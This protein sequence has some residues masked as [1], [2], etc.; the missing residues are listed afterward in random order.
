MSKVYLLG[1]N[2][3]YDRNIPTVKINQIIILEGYGGARY[4]VYDITQ[5]EYG[6][7]YH[8]IN[9]DTLELSICDI[10]RPLSQKFGIGHY[11]DD[12][13]PEF[14]S[15]EK[16]TELLAKAK[17]KK[18]EQDKEAKAKREEYK[19]IEA[20]GAERL[21]KL[22]PANAQAAI[23]G[24]SRKNESDSQTDYYNYSTVRVVL[25][26]FSTHK[27]NIFNE[28]RKFAGNFE[29]T[30][31]L[32]EPNEAYEH[33]ENWSMGDGYYL[34]KSKYSGWIIEKV[35]INNR[36]KF[37]SEYAYMAG[38]EN[39]ICVKESSNGSVIQENTSLIEISSLNI[40]I[41][42][43]SEKAIAVFGETKPIK[44]LL[45][46]LRGAFNRKLTYQGEKKA[47]WVFS[48][49]QTEKVKEAL[50]KYSAKISA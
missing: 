29:G 50:L 9:L 30:S 14:L 37:I 33:R 45:S 48:K 25:L 35:P 26:G 10:V 43:Y 49:N 1:S 31:Y 22:I 12:E 8:L 15:P 7:S 11:Y 38:D 23:I 36:E 39:N 21:R 42:N 18:A 17:I 28:M 34:G 27:R 19:R 41:V 32:S 2:Y 3:V 47:G 5:S 46:G 6:Y 20:I 44:D 16:T 24:C 4:V 40:E 13:N